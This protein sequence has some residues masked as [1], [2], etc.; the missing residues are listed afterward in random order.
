MLC[1][2]KQGQNRNNKFSLFKTNQPCLS[3]SEINTSKLYGSLLYALCITCT[4]YR[5]FLFLM[6]FCNTLS[7]WGRKECAFTIVI[8][9]CPICRCMLYGLS[10][11]PAEAALSLQATSNVRPNGSFVQDE[12]PAV[13]HRPLLSLSRDFLLAATLALR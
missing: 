7:H 10:A 13:A 3:L 9:H 12:R 5:L 11:R 4:C 6:I 2:T 8:L 1:Q